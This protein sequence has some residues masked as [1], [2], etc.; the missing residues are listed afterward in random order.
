MPLTPEIEHHP[1]QPFLPDNARLLMLGSFP[2]TKE[3]W[4]MDFLKYD[5]DTFYMSR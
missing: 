4:C 5:E 3:R 1:L 2:P